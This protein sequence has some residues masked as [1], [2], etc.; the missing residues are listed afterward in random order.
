VTDTQHDRIKAREAEFRAIW[1]LSDLRNDR[2]RAATGV[3]FRP[4]E[5]S[6]RDCVESLIAVAGVQV[7]RKAAAVAA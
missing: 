4:L 3:A 1:A 5:E 6:I 2:M 7:K